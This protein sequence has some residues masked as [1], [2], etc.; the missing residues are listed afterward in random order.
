LWVRLFF[1]LLFSGRLCTVTRG[2]GGV[3]ACCGGVRE[4]SFGGRPEG[5][6]H[7]EGLSVDEV[8]ILKWILKK[9]AGTAWNKLISWHCVYRSFCMYLPHVTNSC[10]VYLTFWRRNYFLILAHSV[11]KIWI[12]QEP[13][14]LELWNKLHFEE[15]ETESIHHV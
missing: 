14:T 1:F 7:W 3:G 8:I 12:I 15:K 10:I 11:Y 13:N 5:Q 4:T 2:D 9:W 6:N